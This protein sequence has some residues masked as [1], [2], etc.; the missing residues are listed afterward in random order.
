MP[1]SE[2]PTF[3]TSIGTSDLTSINLLGQDLAH[4]LMGQLASGSSPSGSSRSGGPPPASCASSR[5]SWSPWPTT[6]SPRPPS[7]PG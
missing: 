2:L 5:L 6:G 3:P 4:D 1:S 7:R